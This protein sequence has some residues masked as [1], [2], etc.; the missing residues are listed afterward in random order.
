[1]AAHPLERPSALFPL[2]LD[3]LAIDHAE[4]VA[5]WVRSPRGSGQG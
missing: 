4:V 2:R 1:M 3:P 5:S